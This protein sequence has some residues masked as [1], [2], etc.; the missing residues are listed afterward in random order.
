MIDLAVPFG[1]SS[2]ERAFGLPWTHEYLQDLFAQ[3]RVD[4]SAVMREVSVGIESMPPHDVEPPSMAEI[5][6]TD[7]HHV[8][9]R[10]RDP[11]SLARPPSDHR[12]AKVLAAVTYF[13]DPINPTRGY[14]G[15]LPFNITSTDSAEDI[16]RRMGRAP[17]DASL[18]PERR[19]GFV[20]WEDCS[21]AVH[22]LLTMP[23]QRVARVTAYL[24]TIDRSAE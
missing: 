23:S 21:P 7:T 6:L 5:D 15:P 24:P 10:F 12:G 2:L 19:F 16:E 4:S 11:G 20:S 14:Q 1:W 17:T 9:L 13:L 8:R 22:A 3:A 18:D